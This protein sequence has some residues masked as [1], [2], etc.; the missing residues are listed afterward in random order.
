[1]HASCFILLRWLFLLLCS[2]TVSSN[3]MSTAAVCSP[4]LLSITTAYCTVPTCSATSVCGLCMTLYRLF[5]L[6]SLSLLFLP[7]MSVIR[8]SLFCSIYFL[9]SPVSSILSSIPTI[10]LFVLLFLALTPCS[11]SF[12]S[13]CCPFELFPSISHPFLHSFL[14]SPR[15]LPLPGCLS[16]IVCLRVHGGV[17]RAPSCLTQCSLLPASICWSSGPHRPAQRAGWGAGKRQ[18]LPKPAQD[19]ISGYTR[20]HTFTQ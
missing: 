15:F 9:S 16:G 12:V 8:L 19:W 17:C 18:S 2:T 10:P 3:N 13:T 5:F 6:L 14:S 4:T 11:F 7:T 20:T 1:M